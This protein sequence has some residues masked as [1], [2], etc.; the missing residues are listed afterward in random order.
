MLFLG[1]TGETIEGK[2]WIFNRRCGP[3]GYE[4]H[5]EM[6]D[7]GNL[8]L[9]A[10]LAPKVDSKCETVGKISDTLRFERIR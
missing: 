9:L 10:G 2:A 1:R 3:L 6:L 5:G 8:V 7:G 4:V